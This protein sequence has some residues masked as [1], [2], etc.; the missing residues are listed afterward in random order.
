MAHN[1]SL[2]IATYNLHGINQGVT[3]LKELCCSH[4]IIFIQEHWLAPFNIS[5]LDDVSPD[6]LCYAKSAMSDVISSKFLVGR[7]FGG[8]AVF[9]KQNLASEFKVI[10][11]SARYIILKAWS[12]LFI[13]VYLPCNSATDWENEYVECLASVLNDISTCDVEYKHI[14]F[15]GDLNI[16]FGTKNAVNDDMRCFMNNLNLLNLDCKLPPGANFSFR[17]D[18][19]GATS[20]IDHFFVSKTLCNSIIDMDLLD[21][22][23]NLSDHCAVSLEFVLPIQQPS[24]RCVYTQHRNKYHYSYRWDKSDLNQYYTASYEYLQAVSV[25]IHLLYAESVS[26]AT[27]IQPTIDYFYRSI[28]DSLLQASSISVRK[29]KHNFYKYWWDEELAALK[30]ASIDSFKLWTA[31]GKPRAGCEF[32]AMK[33]AK[34]AYK[35]AIKNKEVSSKDAFTNSLNEAL[36]H[37]NMDSFWRSWRSKFGTEKQSTVVDGCSEELSIANKFATIFQTVCMP[38]SPARHD[39]LKTKFQSQFDSYCGEQS[40][41]CCTVELIDDCIRRVKRGRAAGHDHLTVEHLLY[42]HPILLTFLTILFNILKLHGTVPHDFCKGIIIPLIK[43]SDGDKSSSDNYRGITLSPVLSKVF[44]LVLLNDVKSY[45]TSDKLQFG[46]KQDSSCAHA[47]FTMRSVVEHYCNS[48]STVAVCALDIAKAFD[49]VDHYALLSLLIDRKVPKYFIRIMLKWFQ[50][51]IASVRWGGALSAVFDVLAG[52]RQGGL[53]SPLLF[54]VYMDVLIN[55]L[56]RF[57]FGCYLANCYFGCL[58]YAD[59]II[60]LSHSVNAMRIMLNVCEQFALDFDMKFNTQKSVVM[61]IGERCDVTCAH[62]TLDG[63]ELI[64]VR[65]LKYLGVHL[66]A[67]KCFS[68]CVKNVRMKF[69][70]TFNA[71]YYR[72]KGVNTEL[73]TLHLFK[74]YCLPFILYGTEAVPLNKTALR[75]LDDCI[76]LAVAKIFNVKDDNIDVVRSYCDLPYIGDIIEKRRLNFINRFLNYQYG[77]CIFTV[78]KT[79]N[80]T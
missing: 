37:K 64:F 51:S 15:G 76:K 41:T 49:R 58:V 55:R 34:Y 42:A 10:K 38:N 24:A 20:L 73:V 29:V 2:K 50:Y 21:S 6:F 19:T 32:L 28:V 46:F 62:L 40:T 71:I 60:L 56:R 7:P 63:K 27:N 23:I 79:V 17:V 11:L 9:I 36:L 1:L 4:D 72:S 5:L 65:S 67:G 16:N 77:G 18:S 8:V 39:V 13:N 12:T 69:Y 26:D 68:C 48:G 33:R 43:N 78:P 70:R 54:S 45:L 30:Q 3:F 25:P 31:V 74:S 53:L 80:Q 22:G 66:V 59:D 44:E 57:G 47:I 75:R 52:V 14:V 35:L 61:R